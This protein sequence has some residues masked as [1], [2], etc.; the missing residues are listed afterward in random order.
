MVCCAFAV[1]ILLQILTPARRLRRAL[2]GED[3]SL[4]QAALWTPSQAQAA[5]P[6]SSRRLSHPGVFAAA[7]G[8]QLFLLGLIAPLEFPLIA[9][10]A[11]A[12]LTAH[13]AL[14]GALG[15]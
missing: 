1:L 9:Q 6:Q 10:A 11:Q 14:C 3:R 15:L 12:A 8:A 5:A 2:F 7:I 13:E 4:D